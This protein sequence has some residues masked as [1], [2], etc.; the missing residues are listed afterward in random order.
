MNTPTLFHEA[1]QPARQFAQTQSRQTP[2]KLLVQWASCEDDVRLAQRLRYQVFSQEMGARL[3]P[4]T[5]LMPGLDA[6]AFDPFCDHLLVKLAAFEGDD[7][8]ELVGTYRVLP[9]DAARRAG[10]LYIDTEFDISRLSAFRPTAVELGRSCVHPSWRSGGVI[11]ALWGALC[12]YMLLHR[13][14]TM[15]GCASVGLKN[16][17]QPAVRLWHGLQ[18][19]H[20]VAPQWRVQ[21][22]HALPLDVERAGQ[23][24][25]PD[26]ANDDP[27]LRTSTPPLI[28]GYLR[29]GARLLGPPALDTAFNTADALLIAAIGLLMERHAASWMTPALRLFFYF[30]YVMLA[31]FAGA[32]A[33]AFPKGRVMLASNLFKLG[34]CGMLL[35]HVH[36]LVA[37]GLVGLGAAAYS[38]AKYGILPELLSPEELVSANAWMEVST[39]VSILLGVAL[40]SW[41]LDMQ[42]PA[43]AAVA[44]PA[45]AAIFSIAAV[46]AAAAACALAIP[47]TP[48]RGAAVLHDPRR[49]MFDFRRAFMALWRD[50][51]G[52]VSLAVTSLFW[53]AAAVLQFVVLQWAG[54]ALQL[55]LAQAALL[56]IA[57]AVGM[58]V[59]AVA[60]A[61]WVPVGRALKVLPL[62]LAL[63]GMLL[64]MTVVTHIWSA[65][66]LLTAIGTMAGLFLVPMNALL[67]RRGQLLAHPGQSIAVQNFNE[68]L[69]SLVLLAVYGL[70]LYADVPLM[71]CIVGFGVFMIVAMA[72]I[73]MRQ[74]AHQGGGGSRLSGPAEIPAGSSP[75][76]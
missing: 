1:I 18:T 65:V 3:N 53:A 37:Y 70:L 24:W 26:A 14:Q 33:D 7:D 75:G 28:R 46:Y 21:P 50:Q 76:K 34:G 66:V 27:A 16:G 56:Q 71:T 23:G 41:L 52:Q 5:G 19:T 43:P 63:G 25:G 67:Q 15:I 20:L 42:N 59:G 60:A 12:D 62:G 44:S 29:C 4:P 61:H 54:R 51:E 58:V 72:L 64:M 9:P 73:I 49:L 39:V 68:S 17:R 13:L 69:A 57:V 35:A 11:L 45:M 10:G 2:P 8:G 74:H 36:P 38:P 6:D 32:V 55:P 47:L 22:W 40:G 31:A 30:A 48:A